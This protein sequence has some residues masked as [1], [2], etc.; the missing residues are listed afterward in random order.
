MI[1]GKRRLVAGALDR[2]P[3]RSRGALERRWNG[4]LILNYHRVGDPAGHPGDHAMWSASAEAFD[5]QLAVLARHAD[6]IGPGDLEEALQGKG[7]S[8]MLTFDDGYRDNYEIA[9]PLLRAHGMAATFFLTTGFLDHPRAPWWDELAWMARHAKHP[10]TDPEAVIRQLTEH[11]KALPQDETAAFLD[12]VAHDTGSGPAPADLGRDDWMTWD[13]ARALRAGGMTLG[14]HTADHPVLARL[15]PEEQEDEIR[16][17]S[18]RFREEMG[19]PMRWFAYPVGSRDAFTADT[20][21][22]LREYG[23]RAA[24]SFYGGH[25]PAGRWNPM[26]VPRVHVG[27]SIDPAMLRAMLSVPRLF[28]AA[29]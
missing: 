28:A 10:P 15:S 12:R 22:I 25:Q 2:M 9:Y 4:V 8:V 24:F 20:S 14:G 3:R 26:D 11:Y 23:T 7:R 21:R 1:A 19:E 29:A 18:R 16:R 6:V 5:E 13:M 27:P 17:C